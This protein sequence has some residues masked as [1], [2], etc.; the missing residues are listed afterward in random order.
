MSAAQRQQIMAKNRQ[1]VLASRQRSA[2]LI[3]RRRSL[4]AP[5]LWSQ[6]YRPSQG[7]QASYRLPTPPR[8]FNFAGYRDWQANPQYTSAP[9]YVDRRT[10]ITN[11]YYPTQEPVV[12]GFRIGY[13]QYSP[14]FSNNSFSYR[15]YGYWPFSQS[16]SSPWY[17]YPTLPP[18]LPTEVVYVQ[19]PPA[20]PTSY[21]S[22]SWFPPAQ[23][24]T[25]DTFDYSVNDIQTA[26]DDDNPTYVAQLVPSDGMV[27]VYLDNSYRYSIPA[28][29]FRRMIGDCVGHVHTSGFLV[30]RV[31][32]YSDGSFFV[33]GRHN[34]VDAWGN[35][36][37]VYQTYRLE[38]VNDRYVIRDFGTSHRNYWD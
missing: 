37:T 2:A 12:S 32:H 26:Y 17:Y 7:A 11:V 34:Y 10:Y 25:Y 20:Y 5:A 31:R 3:Q 9:I 16:V 23:G 24:Y 35:R 28:E 6:V 19:E 33:V 15:S 14:G 4:A 36:D 27:A 29:A 22:Y 18:Y 38:P 1:I 8:T 13:T 21:D 30:E